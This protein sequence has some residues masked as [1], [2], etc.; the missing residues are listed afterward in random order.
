MSSDVGPF[1]SCAEEI[2]LFPSV[3]LDGRT[4]ET[5]W[6]TTSPFVS[7]PDDEPP[8]FCFYCGKSDKMGR[9]GYG[10]FWC[11]SCHRMMRPYRNRPVQNV[12]PPGGEI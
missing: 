9:I 4:A 1:D 10:L 3:P 8:A 2:T 7:M 5:S 11:S 12:V 6:L